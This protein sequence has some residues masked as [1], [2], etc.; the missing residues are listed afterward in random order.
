MSIPSI[1]KRTAPEARRGEVVTVVLQRP[2]AIDPEI[3]RYSPFFEDSQG[4]E[5]N[6]DPLARQKA[7]CER[8]SERT[9]GDEELVLPLGLGVL[10]TED[11]LLI[12]P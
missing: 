3:D 2:L 11:R 1:V 12:D 5:Q 6:R 10:S 4:V 9:S 8:H 7:R